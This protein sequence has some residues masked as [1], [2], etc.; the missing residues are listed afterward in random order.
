MVH[1]KRLEASWPPSLSIDLEDAPMQKSGKPQRSMSLSASPPTW[2]FSKGSWR[3]IL[4][5]QLSLGP[6]SLPGW[7]VYSMLHCPCQTSCRG[8]PS[9]AIPQMLLPLHSHHVMFPFIISFLC[10]VFLALKIF[11]VFFLLLDLI[12]FPRGWLLSAVSLIVF[13]L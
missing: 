12:H 1:Y 5:S 10:L 9:T 4:Y 6:F 3:K 8:L 11:L 13:I 7:L 2:I